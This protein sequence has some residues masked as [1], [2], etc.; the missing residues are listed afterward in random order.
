MEAAAAAAAAVPAAAAAAA[1]PAAAAAAAVP[2]AA[3]PAAAQPAP[4]PPPPPPY[5]ASEYWEG[6]YA[7]RADEVAFEWYGGLGVF[8]AA[9]LAALPDFSMRV[10]HVGSGNSRLPEAM[11]ELGFRCQHANDVSPTVVARMARQAAACSGL[12]WGCEDVRGMPHADGSF[13]AVVDKGTYDALSCDGDETVRLLHR[14]VWRVLAPAP[15][16]VYVCISPIETACNLLKPP[17]W[18]AR[19]RGTPSHGGGFRGGGGGIQ[20]GP[21]GGMQGGGVHGGL[22][23][24]EVEW[25][26]SSSKAVDQ[27]WGTAAGWVH[28]CRWRRRPVAATTQQQQQQQQ[29]EEQKEQT[30]K[31]EKAEEDTELRGAAAEAATASRMTE[32]AAIVAA[33]NTV[34]A[35]AEAMARTGVSMGVSTSRCR[36]A[37]GGGAKVSVVNR[38]PLLVLLATV[39]GEASTEWRFADAE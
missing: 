29:E 11:W 24:A 21:R 35:T 8:R 38:A 33:A 1:V 28:V 20:G 37:P 27:R 34:S 4:A 16:G 5:S 10:L 9:L 15:R 17:H 7:A 39:A 3:Q 14:E 18:G 30:E 19:T 25:E 26:V 6:R 36:D 32:L 2:A 12:T 13:D 31:Q 22:T 23:E